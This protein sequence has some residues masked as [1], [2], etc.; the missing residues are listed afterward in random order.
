[1]PKTARINLRYDPH[2]QEGRIIA[3]WLREQPN[4]GQAIRKLILQ[5]AAGELTLRE[6]QDNIIREIRRIQISVPDKPSAED[7]GLAAKIDGLF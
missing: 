7:P 3:R 2:S 4:Y 1:M 6:V 5:A